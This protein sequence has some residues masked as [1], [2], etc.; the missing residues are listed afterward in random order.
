M[1]TILLNRT[2]RNQ[3]DGVMAQFLEWW[4]APQAVIAMAANDPALATLTNL[5]APLGIKNRRARGIVRFCQDYLQL[6]A[7]KQQQ[8][9][10]MASDEV[11]CSSETT[12]ARTIRDSDTVECQFTRQEILNLYHCGEYCADAYE[13]FVQRKWKNIYPKDHALRAYV[14]WQ[15]SRRRQTDVLAPDCRRQQEKQAMD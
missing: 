7:Q 5:I 10:A 6:V 9:A 15:Q 13:I 3:V 8:D 4:P 2:R 1:S 11:S 14:E 12:D